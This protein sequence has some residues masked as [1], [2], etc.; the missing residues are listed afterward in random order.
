MRLL[1]VKILHAAVFITNYT[2]DIT[3]FPNIVKPVCWILV[4]YLLGSS[5]YTLSYD[6]RPSDQYMPWISKLFLMGLCTNITIATKH[7]LYAVLAVLYQSYESDIV[8]YMRK[9]WQLE[10]GKAKVK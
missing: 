6:T 7:N 5:F 8:G 3:L 10:E 4:T 2:L 9:K 1:E